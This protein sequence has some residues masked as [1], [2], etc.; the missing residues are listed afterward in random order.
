M[1]AGIYSRAGRATL[2]DIELYRPGSGPDGVLDVNAWLRGRGQAPFPA[3]VLFGQVSNL[4]YYYGVV[5]A[6]ADARGVQP[7]LYIDMQEELLVV[8]VASSVDQLFNQLARFMELL[9]GEPDFIPGRCSTTT[10]PF[11]AARLIAQDTALVEMM[12]TGRFDGLVTRDEESQ[13]WMQQVLDL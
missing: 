2:G 11:A 13:R 1:L 5:P 10:F 7:V 3:C 12:R 8:P 4:A 9:Q 6:L